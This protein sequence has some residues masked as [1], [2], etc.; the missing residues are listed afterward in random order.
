MT[1]KRNDHCPCGSG[2]KYKQCC[3][4]SLSD[5]VTASFS[6]TQTVSARTIPVRNNYQPPDAAALESAQQ[7]Y[8]KA[9]S[10]LNGN[11]L[12]EAADLF[13]KALAISPA[14]EVYYNLSTV[15]YL[16]DAIVRR[17]QF[18]FSLSNSNSLIFELSVDSII[19]IS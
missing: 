6:S 13:R 18:F 15:Q 2:K 19:D 12:E 17:I 9:C 3:G 1:T 16:A 7:Y 4:A 10:A 14:A 5:S 8:Q 11:N